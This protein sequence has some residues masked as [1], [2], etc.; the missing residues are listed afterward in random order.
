MAKLDF[1]F[2]SSE[3]PEPN[4]DPVPP[5]EYT[6]MI[7]GSD[8]QPTKSGG[9]MIVL[10]MDVQDGEHAG[11]KLFDRLNI[12][13]DNAKTVE[14]AY[15]TLGS[16]VKAVGKKT[17]KD[18]EE[19][20]NIRLKIK[21]AVEPPT[22]YVKDGVQHPGSPQNSVKRYMPFEF[23]AVSRGNIATQQHDG[24]I[25]VEQKAPQADESQLQPWKRKK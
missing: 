14:I 5:G 24:Q 15:R 2:D 16:V 22:P 1:E 4:F 6:V 25:K 11:R 12:K 18:T 3:V 20:H 8:L 7:V 23:V 19:L 17:I 21:V 10:E 13:N 9:E